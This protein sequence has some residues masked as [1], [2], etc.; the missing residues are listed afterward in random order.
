MI[1]LKV[2]T[3]FF[4]QEVIVLSLLKTPENFLEDTPT[5]N[6]IR[7]IIGNNTFLATGCS[8]G[9]GSIIIL[10]SSDNGTTWNHF[11]AVTNKTFDGVAYGNNTIVVMGELGTILSSLDNGKT[12]VNRTNSSVT[13]RYIQHV[14]FGND[15]FVAV[16][17][18]MGQ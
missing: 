17:G 6:L 10:S 16:G 3:V 2:R 13:G 14:G 15:V 12:W 1:L 4:L 5:S 7:Q 8:S 9:C 11:T 18:V